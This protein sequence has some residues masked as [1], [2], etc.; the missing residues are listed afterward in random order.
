MSS[1][2]GGG[3][4]D[5]MCPAETK[6]LTTSREPG[7]APMNLPTEKYSK[8]HNQE[9]SASSKQDLLKI[10][11]LSLSVMSDSWQSHGRGA[12]QAPQSVEF[13]RQEYWSVLPFPPVGELSDLCLQHLL[14]WQADALPLHSLT[15]ATVKQRNKQTKKSLFSLTKLNHTH[16][17]W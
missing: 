1:I 16:L 8:G 13:S 14:H 9:D 2:S 10:C 4:K 11:M 5:P 7:S 6:L 3:T 17:S 15:P 12:H